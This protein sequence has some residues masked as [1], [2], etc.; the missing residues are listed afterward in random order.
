[1]EAELKR[2]TYERQ[3][4]GREARALSLSES[5]ARRRLLLFVRVGA[6]IG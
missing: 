6:V 1:L 3:R 2:E 5:A 4:A